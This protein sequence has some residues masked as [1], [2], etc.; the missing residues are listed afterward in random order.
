FLLFVLVPNTFN[1]LT[2]SIFVGAD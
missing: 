2:I 1:V